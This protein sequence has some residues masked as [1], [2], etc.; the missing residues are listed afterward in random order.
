M[1]DDW[2]YQPTLDDDGDMVAADPVRERAT[3][4]QERQRRAADA[5]WAARLDDLDA[6]APSSDADSLEVGA[7]HHE[8]SYLGF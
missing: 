4:E 5:H 6:T 7:A 3:V 2:G 8:S 1:A